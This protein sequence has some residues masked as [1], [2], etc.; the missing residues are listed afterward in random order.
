[1]LDGNGGALTYGNPF[2]WG[3]S[4][5]SLYICIYVCMYIIRNILLNTPCEGNK[6]ITFFLYYTY[7]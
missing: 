1:M 7:N 6:K 4:A 3:V 5:M 2:T